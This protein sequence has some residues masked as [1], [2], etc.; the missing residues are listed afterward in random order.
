MD[1]KAARE[2]VLLAGL[3]LL[4]SGL[5]SGTWGN[6]SQRIDD[7]LLVITPSGK[8]Y[9]TLSANDIVVVNINTMEFEGKLKPSSECKLHAELYKTRDDI[10]AIIHTHSLYASIVAAARKEI[11][12]MSSEML[13]ILGATIPVTKYAISGSERLLKNTVNTIGNRNAILLANHGSFCVGKDMGSAFTCCEILE[14]SCR[15]Y[16]AAESSKTHE[17]NS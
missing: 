5:V 13:E 3:K 6:V 7:K 15:S 9:E 2:I 14:Q 16:I 11:P 12:C 17:N 8:D 10:N 4:R 1:M